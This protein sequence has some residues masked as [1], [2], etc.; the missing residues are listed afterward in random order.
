MKKLVK[1]DKQTDN[2]YL[3]LYKATFLD[4]DN[5]MGYYIASRRKKET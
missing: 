4:G 1:L 2:K 3:N 5:E